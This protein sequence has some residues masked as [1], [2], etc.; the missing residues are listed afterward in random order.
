VADPELTSVFPLWGYFP[1][2]GYSPGIDK[3]LARPFTSSAQ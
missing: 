2:E 3:K 1:I